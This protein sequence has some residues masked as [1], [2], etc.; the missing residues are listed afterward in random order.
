[1]V[2]IPLHG[3]ATPIERLALYAEM[4]TMNPKGFRTASEKK[5][6]KR[7]KTLGEKL[8]EEVENA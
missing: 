7:I 6:R 2:R 5:N 1:M 3:K 8:A 4:A